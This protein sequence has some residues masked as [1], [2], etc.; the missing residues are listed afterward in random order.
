MNIENFCIDMN[1]HHNLKKY[2]V[3][4]LIL[5]EMHEIFFI[6]PIKIKYFSQH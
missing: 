4:I 2:F 6:S 5:L 3:Y 1:G